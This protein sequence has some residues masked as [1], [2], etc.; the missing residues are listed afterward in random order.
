MLVLVARGQHIKHAV[1]C[2]VI[3]DCVDKGIIIIAVVAI[4]RDSPSK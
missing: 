2:I 3:E 1:G 4:P